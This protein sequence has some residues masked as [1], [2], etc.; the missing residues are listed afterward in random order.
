MAQYYIQSETL[1][2]IANAIRE[3]NGRDNEYTPV[4]MAAAIR[5]LVT[6]QDS[7]VSLNFEV[8]G[9]ETQPTTAVE[10][11]IWV[12]TDTPISRWEFNI[13]EPEIYTEGMVW[14][15]TG[16]VS[17]SAFNA[18]KENSI[19]IYPIIAKQYIQNEWVNKSSW[20]YQN[21]SWKSVWN[22]Y[23]FEDGEQYVSLT[24]GWVAKAYADK[25]TIGDTISVIAS[26]GQY[27]VAGTEN[28]VDLTNI[29]TLYFDSPNGK[30][31]NYYKSCL[32]VSQTK[33][34]NHHTSGAAVV[35]IVKGIGSLDVASLEG[36]YYINLATSGG[37]NGNGYGDIR[38][39]WGE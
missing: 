21:G 26:Q 30:N 33:N 27:T 37:Q 39:V 15:Y 6:E 13:Y 29:T 36:E 38:A 24:G 5:A 3:K 16:D 22:G 17:I 32:V 34:A 8:V 12:L 18:L 1:T 23:Y 4:Q 9:S 14:I 11:T 7:G 2:N 31:G 28:P 35:D 10:N 20:I 19:M 25:V